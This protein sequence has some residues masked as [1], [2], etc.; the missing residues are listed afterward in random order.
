MAR[1]EAVG[2]DAALPRALL[3]AAA[4]V[5]LLLGPVLDPGSATAAAASTGAGA[6]QATSHLHDHVS[7]TREWLPP[8]AHPTL[9]QVTTIFNHWRCLSLLQ[10]AV[11]NGIP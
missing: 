9:Q 3:A 5:A 11:P 4:S 8:S 1:V 10:H 6:P 2:M 7:A